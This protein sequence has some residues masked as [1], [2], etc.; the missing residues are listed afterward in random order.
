MTDTK[1]KP[2]FTKKDNS[3]FVFNADDKIVATCESDNKNVLTGMLAQA[4]IRC[5]IHPDKRQAWIVAENIVNDN[6]GGHSSTS[7][8]DDFQSPD[9]SASLPAR[10]KEK[11]DELS[12]EDMDLLMRGMFK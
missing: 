3:I 10:S 9:G 1:G 12:D 8:T 7:R 4:I 2:Y 6:T 5:G 11:D